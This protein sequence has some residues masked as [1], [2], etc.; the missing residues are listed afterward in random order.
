MA[1]IG[2]AFFSIGAP[3]KAGLMAL[4]A[5]C[6]IKV[7]IRRAHAWTDGI[8]NTPRTGTAVAALDKMYGAVLEAVNE[9]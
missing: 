4:L 2:H 3:F 7:L 8:G 9:P 1:L 5:L 6:A